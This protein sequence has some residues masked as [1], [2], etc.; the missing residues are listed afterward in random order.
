MTDQSTRGILGLLNSYLELDFLFLK[1]LILF[2][3]MICSIK[4]N[5]IF[6][7]PERVLEKKMF[8]TLPQ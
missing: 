5:L 7:M 2:S 3:G 1:S 8:N 4:S 6:P